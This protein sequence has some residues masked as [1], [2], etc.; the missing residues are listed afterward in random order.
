MS[1]APTPIT[2][3]DPA[4]RSALTHR[5]VY[6][7]TIFSSA[8]LLFQVQPI[9]TKLILPWFGGAAAVWSVCLLFFQSVLLVGYL[10]AHLLTQHF[11][12]RTQAW[13]HS[14]FL[15]ASL[16][17]LPILPRAGLK[18]TGWEDPASRVLL[19][20]LISIGLPYFLLSS[21]S[22]LL[23]A[24]LARSG[25]STTPYRLYALSNAGSLLG[26]LSYPVAVEP[27][28]SNHHQATVWSIAYAAVAVLCAALALE[29]RN[30]PL[31]PRT[32]SPEP[33]P[34]W[35]LKALWIALAACGSALLL[36]I[37]NH[38]SQNIAAVPLLWIIPLSLYLLTF[39]ICFADRG[40]YRRALFLRLLAV[41][42]ACMAFALAP[43]PWKSSSLCS[44]PALLLR[45]VRLLH[46]VSR[47]GVQSEA[48]TRPFDGFLSL[49]LSR[50]RARCGIRRLA[51]SPHFF[52]ILRTSHFTRLLRRSYSYRAIPRRRHGFTH[53][54]SQANFSAGKFAC[55]CFLRQPLCERQARW[56]SGSRHCP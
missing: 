22:P 36:S 4:S 9:I 38:I 1:L 35:Q 19:V 18:P 53:A 54:F 11:Q 12:P 44:C 48:S 24:W 7:I 56:R 30:A 47:R 28:I 50:R 42:L 27:R 21:T 3:P 17:V 39:I 32:A 13:I 10:Y 37:T 52:R 51:R 43:G 33:S 8:F 45:P 40:W 20:L 25:E 46:G 5:L 41:A 2:Q 23:Q 14:T 29:N 49:H 26:L 34:A 31:S 15:A 16:F 55:D 6:G